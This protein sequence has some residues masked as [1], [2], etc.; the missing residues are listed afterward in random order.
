MFM[1]D[2]FL[3]ILAIILSFA[4]LLVAS[5]LILAVIPNALSWL[6]QNDSFGSYCV[7]PTIAFRNAYFLLPAVV[8][9]LISIITGLFWAKFGKRMV[10]V[11]AFISM[12]PIVLFFL[13]A[14]DWKLDSILIAVGYFA[15]SIFI[16]KVL[17]ILVTSNL[18]P[19][20]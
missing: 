18:E 20:K 1:K 15:L 13:F 4:L 11:M 7:D 14:S 10:E 3:T 19:I 6:C 12:M 17:R 8:L 5:V 2:V 16:A 9:P